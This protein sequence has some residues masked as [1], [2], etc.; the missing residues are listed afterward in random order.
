[1]KK[2]INCGSEVNEQQKVCPECGASLEQSKSL[3]FIPFLLII[4]IA[5][6][7]MSY[8]GSNRQDSAEKES[9]AN[10]PQVEKTGTEGGTSTQG[11]GAA[12]AYAFVQ[13]TVRERLEDSGRVTFPLKGE[14]NILK[15]GAANY[16][17]KSYV[18]VANE[19]GETTWQEFAAEIEKGAG[20]SGWRLISLAFSDT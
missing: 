20:N 4:L 5:V 18:N 15:I 1:M 8:F 9:G 2:C 7:I 19:S 12:T 16:I 11:S 13:K 10:T 6:T 14:V 17:V 3:G